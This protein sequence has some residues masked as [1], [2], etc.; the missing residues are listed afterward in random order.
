VYSNVKYTR[1]QRFFVSECIFL[2]IFG[3]AMLPI[4][5][6]DVVRW[7]GGLFVPFLNF[8]FPALLSLRLI[9]KALF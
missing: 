3:L 7:K 6:D 2:L 1:K 9:K 4:S 8:I 5:I